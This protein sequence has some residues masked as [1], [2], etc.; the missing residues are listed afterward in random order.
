[1]PLRPRREPLLRHSGRNL[2]L[3]LLGFLLQRWLQ[4]PLVTPLARQVE[5]HNLGL[6]RQRPLRRLPQGLQTFLAL[7][8]LDYTIYLWHVLLHRVPLLWRFHLVHHADLDLDSSTALRFHAGELLCSIPYRLAQIRLLGIAPGSLA[9]WQKLFFGSVVFHHANLRLSDWLDRWLSPLLMTPRLH[10]IH[11][12]TDPAD[13]DANFSAGLTLWDR[14][15]RSL[16]GHG[17]QIKIGV[18]DFQQP[19]E[20][21]LGKL[22]TLPFGRVPPA[23]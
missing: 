19:A 20:V 14:L 11:H 5:A 1:M 10:G 7:L 17:S 16:R 21:S 23:L 9:L 3:A 12:S 15:H 6:L 4:Q 22:L 18:A 8:L 2:V 13:S